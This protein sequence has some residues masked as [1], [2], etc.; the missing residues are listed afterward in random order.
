LKKTAKRDIDEQVDNFFIKL[1]NHNRHTKTRGVFVN[2][3]S[4]EEVVKNLEVKGIKTSSMI[5]DLNNKKFN[6]YVSITIREKFGFEDGVII[7]KDGEISG[8]YYN[9]LLKNKEL[10][11]KDAF[12]FVMNAFGAEFGSLDVNKLS[13]EQV[14]LMLTFNEKSKFELK[15]KDL[16]KKIKTKYDENLVSQE[17]GIDVKDEKYELFKKIGLGNLGI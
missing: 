10:Y 1:Q 15:L 3:P 11:G 8:S 2:I 6:G 12:T 7:F 16:Q 17:I 9:F 13:K 4:G 5:K 14:E